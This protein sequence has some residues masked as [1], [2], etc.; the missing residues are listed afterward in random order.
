VSLEPS[1][2]PDKTSRISDLDELLRS[3]HPRL[4]DGV[5]V[6]LSSTTAADIADIEPIATFRE[7]EGLSIIVEESQAR[8]TNLPILFRAAWIT[9]T[10]NSDLYAVGLT[11]AVAGALAH[12]GISCN[13]VAGANHD[14]LFVP[15]ELADAAMAAL[16][17]LR[18]R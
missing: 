18:I 7:D 13:V 4:N 5:Y 1:F 2:K 10:V 15:I 12:K 8:A 14:H 9:L 3:M 17:E 11:A 6:F 16:E